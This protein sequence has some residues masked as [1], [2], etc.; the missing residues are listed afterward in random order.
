MIVNQSRMIMKLFIMFQFD[1]CQLMRM[2]HNE[3]INN[4]NDKIYERVHRVS[5]IAMKSI[6]KL[7]F[8]IFYQIFISH[9]MI[10]LQKLWKMFFISSKKLFSFSK[11][12]NFCISAFPSFSP[13]SHCF[14]GWSKINLKVYDVTTV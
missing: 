1:F 7:L 11:Y 6:L 9:Q 13:V 14:R 12:S 4:K 5:Y 2:D 8:T 3:N 10:V